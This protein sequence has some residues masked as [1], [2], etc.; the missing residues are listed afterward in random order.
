MNSE[1]QINSK[2]YWNW[3][4]KENWETYNGSE[5][6][7]YFANILLSNTLESIFKTSE[8]YLDFG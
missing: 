5:Q 8:T 6:T 2:D 1:Y 7:A 3:R 4:Y